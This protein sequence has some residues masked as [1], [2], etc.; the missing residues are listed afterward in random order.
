MQLVLAVNFQTK[1]GSDKEFSDKEYHYLSLDDIK[2]GDL[3]VASTTNGLRIAKVSSILDSSTYATSYIIQKIDLE[4][5]EN[6]IKEHA[7][8]AS[9]KALLDL[10]IKQKRERDFYQ[11]F[12]GSDDS[13]I[14]QMA[15]AYL[16]TIK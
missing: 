14:S 13:E 2:I 7:E 1:F 3:V 16:E 15:A 12:V 5:Y 10:K 9:A 11:K 6:K 4:H 8:A